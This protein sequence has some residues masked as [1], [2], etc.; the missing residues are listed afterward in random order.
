MPV[1]QAQFDAA[2]RMAGNDPECFSEQCYPVEKIH[3]N[4]K[5]PGELKNKTLICPRGYSFFCFAPNGRVFLTNH[6][7]GIA[8]ADGTL[9]IIAK[10]QVKG[11]PCDYKDGHILTTGK[12]SFWLYC[13]SPS[14]AVRIYRI[15]DSSENPQ[16]NA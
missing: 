11:V 13:Y 15:F 5:A 6:R 7:G 2:E 9:K 1:S 16:S 8:V 14:E 4:E 10:L 12:S 3:F